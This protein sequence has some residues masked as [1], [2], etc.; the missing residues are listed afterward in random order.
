MFMYFLESLLECTVGYYG[1]GCTQRC[2]H[3]MNKSHCHNVNGHCLSGC[4]AGYMGTL[5]NKSQSLL[6]LII[7]IFLAD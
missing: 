7:L 6:L 3:C 1:R 5:C 4:F 2:G